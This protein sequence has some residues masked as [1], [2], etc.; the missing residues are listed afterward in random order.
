MAVL[1]MMAKGGRLLILQFCGSSC[2]FMGAIIR[3]PAYRCFHSRGGLA[4]W[5]DRRPTNRW[6]SLLEAIKF[7]EIFRG[8][9]EFDNKVKNDS[10]AACGFIVMG[11]RFKC[12]AG[13]GSP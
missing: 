12:L 13:L 7:Y 9:C 4:G 2:K 6:V 3:F 10:L 11:G 5:T 1:R 8:V